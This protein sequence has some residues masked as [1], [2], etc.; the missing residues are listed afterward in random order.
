MSIDNDILDINDLEKEIN[1][2]KEEAGCC[3]ID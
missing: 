2:I 1:L 3:E